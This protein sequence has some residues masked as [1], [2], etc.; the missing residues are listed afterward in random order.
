MSN[1]AE[2]TDGPESA[3]VGKSTWRDAFGW[4][5]FAGIVNAV[6]IAGLLAFGGFLLSWG[7]SPARM[8]SPAT[9][10]AAL[11][12]KYLAK[13]QVRVPSGLGGTV[14]RGLRAPGSSA[15]VL[16]YGAKPPQ[17]SGKEGTT[18]SNELVIYDRTRGPLEAALRLRPGERS[19]RNGT[20]GA[21]FAGIDDAS[22]TE[23]SKDQS[24]TPKMT[25]TYERVAYRIQLRPPV[26][27]N[28]D[29]RPENR[30]RSQ[31]VR[32]GQISAE[33]GDISVCLVDT[34]KR[35]ALSDGFTSA[36][37]AVLLIARP[38][39]FTLLV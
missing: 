17:S 26:D 16:V 34:I 5:W 1:D 25:P 12:A 30:R 35:R 27:L 32:G 15:L 3:S 13:N 28:G 33:W 38:S 6:I 14:V 4:T 7:G 21:C 36:V 20:A 31:G 11:D 8:P 29:G 37:G 39:R 24:C 23:R 9:Q 10:V 18:S 19:V 2:P 22:P